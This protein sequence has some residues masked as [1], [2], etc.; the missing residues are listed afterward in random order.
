MSNV[1]D[2]PND[3]DNPRRA[4]D[5][6]PT[7]DVVPPSGSSDGS[8][9]P[10]TAI[11]RHWRRYGDLTLIP[12]DALEDMP[13]V[14]FRHGDVVAISEDKR[15]GCAVVYL[16]SGGPVKV[17]CS[18][19]EAANHLLGVVLDASDVCVTNDNDLKL[20]SRPDGSLRPGFRMGRSQHSP[21]R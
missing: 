6:D 18:F 20:P 14:L 16:R 5:L 11:P 8:A 15:W 19:T 21:S 1:N 3:T 4:S 17:A 2:R 7:R 9:I 13:S 10:Q 12:H